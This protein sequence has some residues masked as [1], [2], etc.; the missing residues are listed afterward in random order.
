MLTEN[1]KFVPL[2]RT[3]VCRKGKRLAAHVA[4]HSTGGGGRGEQM[5]AEW[6]G[7]GVPA[8]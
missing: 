7:A 6:S 1:N 5:V 4:E 8:H 2:A 3:V